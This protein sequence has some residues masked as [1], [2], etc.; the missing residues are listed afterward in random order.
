MI[1]LINAESCPSLSTVNSSEKM[2]SIFSVLPQ[3]RGRCFL[4][5]VLHFKF[6]V[7]GTEM[8][9]FINRTSANIIHESHTFKYGHT[10]WGL[11]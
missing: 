7:M 11:Y 2:T 10:V 5:F 9:D 8:F 6:R 3:Y 1:V 4:F